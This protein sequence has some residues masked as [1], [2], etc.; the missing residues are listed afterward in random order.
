MAFQ[1]DE[2]ELGSLWIKSGS[3]GEYMTGTINGQE[4][5]VWRNDRK[6]GNQPDWRVMKS[7]PREPRAETA[8]ARP[9]R[10]A[11]NPNDEPDF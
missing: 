9:S 11:Y 5:V 1:R 3:K 6:T 7:K 8:S 2:N 10:P 4:V